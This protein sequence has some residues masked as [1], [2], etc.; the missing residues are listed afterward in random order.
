M[1]ALESVRHTVRRLKKAAKPVRRRSSVEGLNVLN[2]DLLGNRNAPSE[3]CRH[4][5]RS[6]PARRAAGKSLGLRRS[7]KVCE[8]GGARKAAVGRLLSCPTMEVGDFVVTS[9]DSPDLAI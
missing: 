9:A 2:M 3:G 6:A 4:F 5:C 7:A 8:G 1:C